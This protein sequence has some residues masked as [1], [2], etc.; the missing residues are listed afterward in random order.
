MMLS[1]YCF[2]MVKALIYSF[3]NFRTS[4]HFSWC[5]QK[6][7]PVHPIQLFVKKFYDSCTLVASSNNS[8]G[9]KS[10][11]LRK[12]TVELQLYD[13]DKV[14]YE[15]LEDTAVNQ[16]HGIQNET[17]NTGEFQKWSPLFILEHAWPLSMSP[18]LYKQTNKCICK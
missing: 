2:I 14:V 6:L 4:P 15:I 17:K 10:F 3:S 11:A 12:W 1:I 7:E 16:V 18:S 8:L 5:F 9:V 13:K